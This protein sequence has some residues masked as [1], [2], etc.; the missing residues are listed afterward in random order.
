MREVM[1]QYG[2]MASDQL[3]A[4]THRKG[5]LWYETAKEHDLLDDFD[6]CHANSFNVVID[7]SRQLCP[8]DRAYYNETLEKPLCGQSFKELEMTADVTR[9]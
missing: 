3:I 2:G 4:E 7:M 5:S 8:D 1:E 9:G 6:Q